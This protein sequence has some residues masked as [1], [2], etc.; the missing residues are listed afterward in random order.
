MIFTT[1]TDEALAICQHYSHLRAH[2][3]D[4]L[5]WLVKSPSYFFCCSSSPPI[6]HCLLA[7]RGESAFLWSESTA[8]GGIPSIAFRW[9]YGAEIWDLEDFSR[10]GIGDAAYIS[11][12]FPLS[13][14]LKFLR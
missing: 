4:Y 2:E 11:F 5:G 7:D 13:S 3:R 8:I 12:V 10:D 6:F 1:S 9:D 14:P